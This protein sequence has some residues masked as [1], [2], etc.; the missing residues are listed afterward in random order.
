MNSE[1]PDSLPITEQDNLN[2]ANLSSLPLRQILR[3]MNDEDMLVAAAV[4]LVLPE[5][6]DAVEGIVGRIRKDR[7]SVV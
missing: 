4:G 5:V 7:K 2:T 3:V 6:G 1:T